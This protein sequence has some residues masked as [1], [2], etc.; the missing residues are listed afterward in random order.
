MKVTPEL[1]KS[2]LESNTFNRK[3]SQHTVQKYAAD[4]RSGNWHLN[5]QGIAFDDKGTMVDGQHRLFA[6]IDSGV[7]IEMMVTWGAERTGI[8][9]LRVRS[10][11]DVIKFGSLSDWLDQKSISCAKAMWVL[12]AQIEGG[13]T[14]ISTSALVE[15][16]EKNKEAITFS[17]SLFPSNYK[18]ISSA[19]TRA[20]VAFAFYHYDKVILSEFVGTLYSGIVSNPTK[21]AAIRCREMLSSGATSGG[22]K[23]RKDASF[24]IMRAIEAF[25]CEKPLSR[26]MVPSKAPFTLPEGRK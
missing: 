17:Q 24:K 23:E 11:A 1:A 10:A 19:A 3:V 4:M 8:D 14:V 18:G 15:F 2:W 12:M 26:L 7:T 5:H 21:S 9:E 20:S 22:W 13:S 6:V 16:A 25:A